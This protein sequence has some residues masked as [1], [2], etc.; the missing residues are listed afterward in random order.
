MM[1]DSVRILFKE[2][3][4]PKNFSLLSESV[5]LK[6]NKS[7]TSMKRVELAM[8]AQ[9]EIHLNILE[10]DIILVLK[11]R[12]RTHFFILTRSKALSD[13]CSNI[14]WCFPCIVGNGRGFF[15]PTCHPAPCGK[16]SSRLTSWVVA[17]FSLSHLQSPPLSR[18]SLPQHRW[19]SL[20]GRSC[21]VHRKNTQ[22][23]V[24]VLKNKIKQKLR[25]SS[26]RK[27]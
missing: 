23:S 19:L 2:I 8:H 15:C 24:T 16:G 12:V 26:L 22:E 7:C 3:S 18:V 13:A 14:P 6:E 4:T 9:K 21:G 5:L 10:W 17:N 1:T 20:G 27:Y 11:E 25:N